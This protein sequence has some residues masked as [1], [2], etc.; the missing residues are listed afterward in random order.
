MAGRA[1]VATPNPMPNAVTQ[2]A[3]P[4]A[5]RPIA[6]NAASAT[7]WSTNT[8]A[9]TPAVDHRRRRA[10]LTTRPVTERTPRRP[11]TV[12]AKPGG[13]PR[14]IRTLTTW[15][16]MTATAAVWAVKAA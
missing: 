15:T 11:A 9:V 1:M 5:D 13:W 6:G 14:R 7:A 2:A 3:A 4:T 10:V 8:A 12:A 16:E